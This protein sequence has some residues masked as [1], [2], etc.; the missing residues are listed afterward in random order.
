MP[1]YNEAGAAA[2]EKSSENADEEEG[3]AGGILN[4]YNIITPTH[5]ENPQ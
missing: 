5:P 2:A 4:K 3:H 1:V